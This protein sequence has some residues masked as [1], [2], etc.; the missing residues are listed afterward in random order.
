MQ[1]GPGASAVD[2]QARQHLACT[3]DAQQASS[4]SR[5]VDTVTSRHRDVDNATRP[6]PAQQRLV[7]VADSHRAHG[8]AGVVHD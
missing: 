1:V 5:A 4:A 6:L 7:E 8:S 2:P 3:L